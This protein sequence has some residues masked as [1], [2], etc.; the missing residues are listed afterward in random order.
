[1]QR[2]EIN[3]QARR[4]AVLG[5]T[6]FVGRKMSTIRSIDRHLCNQTELSCLQRGAT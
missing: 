4:T 1:M 5:V 3:F 2:L 6:A